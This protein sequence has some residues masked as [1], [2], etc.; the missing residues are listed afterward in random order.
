MKGWQR[1]VLMIGIITVVAVT[2]YYLLFS[3]MFSGTPPISRNSYLE[4]ELFGDISEKPVEDPFSK[5]LRGE[6]PSLIGIMNCLKKAKVDPKIKGVVL[7]PM[8]FAAGWAQVQEIRQALEDFKTSGKPVYAYLEANSTKEYYL[9]S[10][11]DTIFGSPQGTL[12]ITGL[13]AGAFF[14]KDGLKKIGVEA[15]FIAHGKYK[16]APDM[17]TRENMSDAQREVLNALLDDIYYTMTYAIAQ[18]RHLTPEQVKKLIDTGVYSLEEGVRAGLVD[19]LMY[20]NEFKEF[21][22]QRDKRRPRLVSYGRYLK[23]PYEKLGMKAEK[24]LGLIFASGNIVSGFGEDSFQD[25]VITSEGMANA[26]RKAADDKSVKA[27][28]IRV[29]SPGG[30]G[31]ASDIIWREVVEARKKKPVVVSMGDVAASGGYYISMAADSILAMP[32]SIIGSIGVFAGKFSIKNLYEKLGINKE[33]IQRGKNADLFSEI[34]KFNKEQRKLMWNFGENFYRVFVSKVAQS[35]NKSYEEIH[36]IAQGRVWSGKR[37]IEIGLVDKWGGLQ[38]AIV[39]AKKLAGI[40]LDEPVYLK[41]FP[42]EK[43]LLEKIAGGPGMNASQFLLEELPQP[44]RN[45]LLGFRYYQEN[46]ILTILPFIPVI[47]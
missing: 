45:Y 47:N 11:A 18:D 42:R 19:T 17:F 15:D 39:V 31:T 37:G 43:T 7:K 28:V 16:N 46:E 32:T 24:K 20:Y 10:K 14:L 8:G 23:I 26:I 2:F 25:G 27:I 35:R 41:I 13:N 34:K 1:I 5:I 33:E 21:L 4:L 29:N 30:S 6:K 44:L 38:D 9:V 40:S 12:F 3:S 22:K 36:R